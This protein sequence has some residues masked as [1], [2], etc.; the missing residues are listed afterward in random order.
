MKKNLVYIIAGVILVALIVIVLIPKDYENTGN[1]LSDV[2]N[3]KIT[4]VNEENKSVLF[5]D[6]KPNEEETIEVGEYAYTDVDNDGD[7]ELVILTTAYSGEYVILHYNKTDEKVYGYVLSS[8]AF[9]D[10][11]TDGSFESSGSA[12][13]TEVN[14]IKFNGNKIEYVNLSSSDYRNNK[15]IINN[16]SVSK[17]EF[18]SFIN[19][20]NKKESV[21]WTIVKESEK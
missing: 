6:L 14:K 3:N 18:E 7:N 2:M 5:K 4:L 21:T 12:Y 15:F 17:E 16:K 8:R 19:D 13:E 9:K 20:W 11:K 1:I 10:L